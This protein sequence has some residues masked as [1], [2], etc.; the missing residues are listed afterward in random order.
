MNKQLAGIILM[1]FVGTFS[2]GQGEKEPLNTKKLKEEQEIMRRILT[3][4]LTDFAQSPGFFSNVN[5]F[6]LAEQGIVLTINTGGFR[7]MPSRPAASSALNSAM[8]ST[9]KLADELAARSR[10]LDRLKA[11]L[12]GNASSPASQ[13]SGTAPPASPDSLD[14]SLAERI[15]SLKKT[16]E[17]L[18]DSIKASIQ[19][20][21]KI[22][23][24]NFEKTL[25]ELRSV[26]IEILATYGDSL[27]IV[28]PAEY[29]SFVLRTDAL[30]RTTS[31]LEII[32]ARKSWIT[33]YKAGRLTLESF[34][35]KVIQCSE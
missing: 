12:P 3:T 32:S 2:W 33:D 13:K 29:I 27:T 15:S 17:E 30:F 34:K 11:Q 24:Q 10:E 5:S 26:L 22:S 35:Q 6:Y 16:I 21:D 25:E 8:E 14:P 23:A 31:G 7:N 19:E 20:S 18:H 9:K 28:K 4:K 1:L